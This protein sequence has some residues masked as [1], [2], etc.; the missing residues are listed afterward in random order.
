VDVSSP[1]HDDALEAF[2]ASLEELFRSVQQATGRGVPGGQ[3]ELTLSQFWVMDAVADEP[4]IVSA[5]ARAA[6][7]AVPTA[8]R[9]LNALERRGFVERRRD[10]GD[11]GRLVTVALTPRGK[12]V[13]DEKRAWIRMRQRE[14][15]DG[16]TAPERRTAARM[17]REI[18]RQ[19]DEL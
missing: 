12:A 4:V 3:T 15:F 19:I 6:R 11:D 17:L 8:T 5:V 10:A 7:I 1:N 14:I 2:A 13:L 16:L 18:A 9:A